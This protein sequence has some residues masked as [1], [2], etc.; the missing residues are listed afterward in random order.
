MRKAMQAICCHCSVPI[1]EV[2]LLR[3]RRQLFELPEN[4]SQA[5]NLGFLFG[6]VAIRDPSRVLNELLPV[7]HAKCVDPMSLT[8][9]LA[10]SLLVASQVC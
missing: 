2:L 1:L 8:R 6:A 4:A 9:E 3:L 7:L 10:Y 5:K